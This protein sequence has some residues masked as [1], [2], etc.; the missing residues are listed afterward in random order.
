M[1]LSSCCRVRPTAPI[2]PLKWSYKL[3]QGSVICN[4][5]WKRNQVRAVLKAKEEEEEVEF[6]WEEQTMPGV[7]IRNR[8]GRER[9][10]ERKTKRKWKPNR[11]SRLRTNGYKQSIWSKGCKRLAGPVATPGIFFRW[12]LKYFK[13]LNSH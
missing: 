3:G 7:R 12:S 6:G 13:I 1:R 11:L 4:C 10:S 2:S 9:E 5:R 8:G